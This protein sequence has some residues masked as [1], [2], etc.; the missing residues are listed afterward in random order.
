MYTEHIFHHP[1]SDI[2]GCYRQPNQILY[3]TNPTSSLYLTT[4]SPSGQASHTCVAL[5]CANVA[6]KLENAI[7]YPVRAEFIYHIFVLVGFPGAL[8]ICQH[9]QY[10]LHYT[11]CYTPYEA[12]VYNITYLD[13]TC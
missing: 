5:S 11:S 4:N 12:M 8:H 6:R 7:S 10:T 1:E 2:I 13:Q 3:R 9:E